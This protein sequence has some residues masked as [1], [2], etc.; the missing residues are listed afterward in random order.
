M[1]ERARRRVKAAR[2][3]V[4]AL[5]DPGSFVE[6]DVLVEGAVTGYGK[7]HDREVYVFAQDGEVPPESLGEAF[8]R[9]AAKVVDLAM[10]NGAPVIGLYDGGSWWGPGLA[11]SREVA[12][13]FTPDEQAGLGVYSELYFRTVMASGF[14]PQIAA[15][16]GPCFGTTACAAAL[17]DLTLMVKGAGLLAVASGESPHDATGLRLEET[18]GAR[19]HSEKTGLACLA[20]DTETECL[21]M[22]RTLLGYLPQN[23]L[24]DP[25]RLESFDPPERKEEW[26]EGV[27]AAPGSHGYDMREVIRRVVDEGEFVELAPNWAENLVIGFA[28]VGGN[29]VGIVA[30]QP[31]VMNGRLDG[32]GSVKAAR[33]VRF[34]DAF[35]LPLV[36][37]VDTPGFVEKEDKPGELLRA[38]AKLMYAFAEAT[39]PKV[40]VITGRAY[41]PAYEL[42]CSRFLRAD[43]NFA[44]S[45]SQI[46]ERPGEGVHDFR[47]SA[48]PFAAAARGLLD[49]VITP[50]ETR[51][52]LVTGLEACSSKREGRPPKKHGNILL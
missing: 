28:R 27:L 35:N 48:S 16:L 30:N 51:L 24:E 6:L 29:A 42:M 12:E 26:L 4:L 41:G 50:S 1:A 10:K 33:F 17:A 25:P 5:L 7:V 13:S 9:K 32:A 15:I 21:E 19:T 18:A 38:A 11:T 49:D 8:V 23:N 47:E 3:R 31:A 36:V 44:W 43:L 45:C 40:T 20:A 22:I 39:V 34:C 2:D 46:A 14:I 37:L 52:R